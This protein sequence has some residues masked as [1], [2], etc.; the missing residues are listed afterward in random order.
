M[1]TDFCLFKDRHILFSK[2]LFIKIENH[3]CFSSYYW[4]HTERWPSFSC[5]I[6]PLVNINKFKYNKTAIVKIFICWCLFTIFKLSKLTVLNWAKASITK[7][8]RGCLP[9]TLCRPW[10]WPQRTTEI[11]LVW[12]LKKNPP[13][14]VKHWLCGWWEGYLI[15]KGRWCDR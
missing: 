15:E 13:T 8:S 4:K 1:L 3:V 7:H 11:A 14:H 9:C 2:P 5:T 6:T 12:C 10:Q